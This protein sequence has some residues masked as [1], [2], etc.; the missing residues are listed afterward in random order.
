MKKISVLAL[1][2]T[3]L[4]SLAACGRTQNGGS[5]PAPSPSVPGAPAESASQSAAQKFLDGELDMAALGKFLRE[6]AGGLQPKDGDLLLERLLL[7]QLDA[8][9]DMNVK[10]WNDPYMAALNDTMGG[11]LDPDKLGNI[12]DEAVRADFQM[13]SDGFMTVD[14]VEETPSVET[15]WQALKALK[16]AFS[17]EAGTMIEYRTHLNGSY[18][19]DSGNGQDTMAADIAAIEKELPLAQSGF[20]RWQLE[21]VYAQL[22]AMLLIGPEGEYL[23]EFADGQEDT[24]DRLS[25]YMQLYDGTRFG[26]TCMSLLNMQAADQNAVSDIIYASTYF[27][28]DDPRQIEIISDKVSGAQLSYPAVRNGDPALTD[29]LNLAIRDAAEGMLLPG[30][31]DQMV[32]NM[33]AVC[34][35][36]LSV[37]LSYSYTDKGG[38]YG[39]KEQNLVLDLTSGKTVTLDDLAG[40]QFAAYKDSL[41]KAL[42]GEKTLTDLKEPVNF[43]LNSDG[44]TVIVTPSAGGYPDY[45]NVTLNGLRAF[46]DISKLY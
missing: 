10:I 27:P 25:K 24:L 6:N 41:L 8:S 31:T 1:I 21:K 19:N 28:P 32:Y 5:P 20:V 14:R 9:M 39:Y 35:N 15:D 33:T 16:G 13:L 26:N 34:G 40:K 11:V 29:E 12:K 30:K 46:I 3:M 23:T 38:E 2:L 17:Q 36:Y 7:L 37:T 18:Y 43:S 45:Y 42:H 4:L 22:V 44:L